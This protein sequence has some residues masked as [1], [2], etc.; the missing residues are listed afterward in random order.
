MVTYIDI[1][2]ALRDILT[3]NHFIAYK[4]K[5]AKYPRPGFH[6][7]VGNRNGMLP[8]ES[9]DYNAWQKQ[10]HKNSKYQEN[11]EFIE[12]VEY[13][14]NQYQFVLICVK[15]NSRKVQ[16]FREF[17]EGSDRLERSDILL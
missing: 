10:Q 4:S 13:T 14:V 15:K 3:A 6:K 5:H 2:L 7:E 12:C 11:P 9:G 17:S 16:I 8:K 1:G